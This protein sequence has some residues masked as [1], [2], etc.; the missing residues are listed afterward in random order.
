M[1]KTKY[2]CSECGIV[3]KEFRSKDNHNKT[4]KVGHC[5]SC[6]KIRKEINEIILAIFACYTITLPVELSEVE[7]GFFEMSEDFYASF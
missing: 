1:T 5:F 7:K 4:F 6:K 3:L 2:A